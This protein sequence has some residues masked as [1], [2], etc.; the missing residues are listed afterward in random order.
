MDGHNSKLQQQETSMMGMTSTT[1]PRSLTVIRDFADLFELLRDPDK[2]KT[3]LGELDEALSRAHDAAAVA[4]ERVKQAEAASAALAEAQAKAEAD[5]RERDKL[6]SAREAELARRETALAAREAAAERSIAEA[7]A[8]R[9]AA[10][11]ARRD[12]AA[13]LAKLADMAASN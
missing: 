2:V 10:D 4:D 9:D 5:G 1:P 3:L 7:A 12:Y 13:R 8:A 6:T 11:N